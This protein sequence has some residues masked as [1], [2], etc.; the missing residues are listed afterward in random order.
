MKRDYLFKNFKKAFENLEYAVEN[1][2]DDLTIDGAIKR[3]ELCYELSWK[4][5]KS[6]LMDLGIVTKSPREC[7]KHACQNDLI[8]DYTVWM[9]MIDDRNLLVH[10]Y[11]FEESRE[12]FKHLK[13]K[14]LTAFGFL[15]KKI[16]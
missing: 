5:M 3:F 6:H 14:Y 1:A 7:F 16:T 9:D 11:T 12:I 15:Y 4:V 10:T 2:K 8:G 13:E